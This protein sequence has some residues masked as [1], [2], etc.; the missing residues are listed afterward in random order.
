MKDWQN[1]YIQKMGTEVSGTPYPV[2]ESVNTWG[3]WCK[4]IP[5]KLYERVKA[6]AMRSWNDEHG[7]D[8][9]VPSTGLY[10]ESYEIEITFGCKILTSL[11]ADEET[12]YVDNVRNAVKAFLDY[13]RAS[14]MM[15]IYSTWTR[16]G[17]QYVRLSEFPETV[18]WVP[19]STGNT[20]FIIFPVK[21]KVCDPVTEVT[22]AEMGITGN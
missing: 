13:L 22:A 9:Y 4:D 14:G 19:G 3:V 21:F 18:K 16:T 15:K 11:F 10:M 6:P 20:E 1:F 17:R 5:F 12:A 7:D 2:F 8:E